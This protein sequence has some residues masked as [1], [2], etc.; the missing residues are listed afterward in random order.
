MNYYGMP[1]QPSLVNYYAWTPQ[2][3]HLTPEW[4]DGIYENANAG[5]YIVYTKNPMKKFI[6]DSTDYIVRTSLGGTVMYLI[7]DKDMWAEGWRIR[8]AKLDELHEH[9]PSALFNYMVTADNYYRK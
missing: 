8:E 7:I 6:L 4:I 9:N 3:R 2:D 5:N 1:A